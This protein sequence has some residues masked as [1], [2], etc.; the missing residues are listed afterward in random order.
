MT[1]S[2]TRCREPKHAPT[3]TQSATPQQASAVSGEACLDARFLSRS[4]GSDRIQLINVGSE[5]VFELT[6][7]SEGDFR[8]RIDGFPIPRLPAGKSVNLLVIQ[9]M[10]GPDTFDLIVNGRT[11]SGDEF[12]ESLFLDLNG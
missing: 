12:T 2:A 5:D 10:G 4:S 7:R 9:V 1:T 8:G 6:S 3:A 11:E